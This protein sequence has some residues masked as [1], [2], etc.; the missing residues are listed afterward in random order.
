V[1][2]VVPWKNWNVIPA[3]GVPL[4]ETESVVAVKLAVGVTAPN[5]FTT[6]NVPA[7]MVVEPV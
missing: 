7:L 2:V 1:L 4:K 3:V 6:L 5:G